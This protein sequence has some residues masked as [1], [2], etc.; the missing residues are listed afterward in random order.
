MPRRRRTQTGDHLGQLPLSIAGYPGDA[1]DFVLVQ[2][3][4]HVPKGWQ[5]LI[6]LGAQRLQDQHR[7]G[8]G[9]GFGVGRILGAIN[10]EYHFPSDHLL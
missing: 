1:E 6:V 10:A 2:R 8:Q 5:S 3:E 7:L 4:R 9:Q